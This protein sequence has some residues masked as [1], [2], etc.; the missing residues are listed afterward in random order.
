MFCDSVTKSSSA[1][2]H[3]T[4]VCVSMYTMQYFTRMKEGQLIPIKSHLLMGE[5]EQRHLPMQSS[6]VI[7][8]TLAVPAWV[9]GC[10]P[11]VLAHHNLAPKK[12]GQG[13]TSFILHLKN[14]PMC[15]S[16]QLLPC[17][18][19]SRALILQAATFK[20]D[21][22]FNKIERSCVWFLP[23]VHRCFKA[24]ISVQRE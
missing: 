20:F 19:T 6:H 23:I 10:S 21:L 3:S 9:S 14:Q 5:V 2:H 18:L 12:W 11:A 15:Q 16:A 13:Q 8:L 22:K 24:L 17:A 7:S 1:P 4:P